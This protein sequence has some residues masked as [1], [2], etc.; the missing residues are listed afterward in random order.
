M[1][2]RNGN[3]LPPPSPPPPPPLLFT[4]SLNFICATLAGMRTL[5]K[6]T[7]STRQQLRRSHVASRHLEGG[8]SALSNTN[9]AKA[10]RHSR[11]TPR[12]LP[13]LARWPNIPAVT[14]GPLP[15][16]GD[17]P[18][19]VRGWDRGACKRGNNRVHS[20]NVSAGPS[21]SSASPTARGT[22]R[23]LAP[24]PLLRR[25]KRRTKSPSQSPAGRAGFPHPPELT[26]QLK[27]A[28]A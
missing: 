19:G 13:S 28:A 22:P 1:G 27:H 9:M 5:K 15:G 12:P 21:D 16:A 25:S 23:F 3:S 11:G 10:P 14:C 8:K 17:G 4:S 6:N 24:R 2:S 20:G 26:W 18:R 7:L